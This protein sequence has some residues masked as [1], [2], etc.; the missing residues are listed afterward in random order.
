MALGVPDLKPVVTGMNT[1]AAA[2]DRHAAAAERA[3][4]YLESR[5]EGRA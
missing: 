5:D 2:I 1:M 3:L 4:D